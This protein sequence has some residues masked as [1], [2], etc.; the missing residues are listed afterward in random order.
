VTSFVL[1]TLWQIKQIVRLI[2]VEHS[3]EILSPG[4][5]SHDDI[6]DLSLTLDII[7]VDVLIDIT[8]C[9][10][11]S[12]IPSRTVNALDPLLSVAIPPGFSDARYL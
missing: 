8:D 11:F 5:F 4:A 7:R 2:H 9:F 10:L 1:R 6:N 12:V 3:L